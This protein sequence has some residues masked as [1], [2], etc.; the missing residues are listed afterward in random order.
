[1]RSNV[2]STSEC[3]SRDDVDAARTL[4]GGDCS[5]DV[6]CHFASTNYLGGICCRLGVF[7]L[8]S[9]LITS[10]VCIAIMLCDRSTAKSQTC[11][12]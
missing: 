9:L 11:I 3:L 2:D 12:V 4:I 5:D 1:M 6:H 10:L 8:F 7:L